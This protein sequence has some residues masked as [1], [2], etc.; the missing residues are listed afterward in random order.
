MVILWWCCCWWPTGRHSSTHPCGDIFGQFSIQLLLPEVVCMYICMYGRMLLYELQ[1]TSLM[2]VVGYDACEC[3]IVCMSK[4]VCIQ[5]CMHVC[6]WMYYC[7]CMF[8]CVY[9]YSMYIPL[10]MLVNFSLQSCGLRRI[11]LRHSSTIL[12]N[13][14]YNY[15]LHHSTY[16][17]VILTKKNN[18]LP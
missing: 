14:K 8:M 3:K 4:N 16:I 10:N 17:H 5:K 11:E 15:Y 7:I 9:M 13:T 1:R 6:M 18:V 12:I 2:Y